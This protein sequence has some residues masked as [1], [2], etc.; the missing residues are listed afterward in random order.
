MIEPENPEYLLLGC[1]YTLERVAKSLPPGSFV[2][3]VRSEA[4][5]KTLGRL[6]IPYE[7]CPLDIKEFITGIFL[8][9]PSLK[10]LIDSVPPMQG[11]A[12]EAWT[13]AVRN[14][15]ASL[16]N[17]RLERI[18]YLSTSGVFGGSDGSWVT[19][20]SPSN[21]DSLK[22]QAR[23]ECEK[24]YRKSGVPTVALRIVGIYGPGRGIGLS[25]KHGRKVDLGPASRWTNRIHVDDLAATITTLAMAPVTQELPQ[26]IC[27]CDDEPVQ[28][29]TLLE[30]YKNLLGLPSEETY[31]A[32]PA[33]ERSRSILN[34]KVS[35]A[36]MKSVTCR[37]LRYPTFREGAGTEFNADAELI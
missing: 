7:F 37:D 31:E 28:V 27:A 3:T 8:K 17:S 30:H 4:R 16:E 12:A 10:V 32:A 6:G 22:S 24:L 33:Q 18:I 2:A 20:A 25:L 9:Y 19:E 11:E 26:I 29:G 15:I 13:I 1:G 36:L 5:A 34:Q 14:V 21:P 35:N 23:L